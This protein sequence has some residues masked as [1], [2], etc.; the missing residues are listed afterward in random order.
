MGTPSWLYYL[1]GL[2]MLAVAGYCLVCW[3]SR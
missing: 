1:F 3:S 2:L